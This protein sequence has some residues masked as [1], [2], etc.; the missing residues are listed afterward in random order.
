MLADTLLVF[1]KGYLRAAAPPAD[2]LKPP[3]LAA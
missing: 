3:P 2:I 1:D